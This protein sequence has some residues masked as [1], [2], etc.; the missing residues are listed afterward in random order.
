MAEFPFACIWMPLYQKARLATRELVDTPLFYLLDIPIPL[1]WLSRDNLL[2]T[3]AFQIVPGGVS[4][5]PGRRIVY[6]L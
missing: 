4:L 6:L 2:F 5:N 1:L 3:P